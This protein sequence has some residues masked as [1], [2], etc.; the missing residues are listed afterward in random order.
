MTQKRNKA[1]RRRAALLA[2]SC[3][4]SFAVTGAAFGQA[5]PEIEATPGGTIRLSVKDA[6]LAQVLELLSIRTE[7]NIITSKNVSATISANLYDVTFEEALKAILEVNGFTSRTQGDF[8][9]IYTMEEAA[10]MD[11]RA[12]VSES[13]SFELEHLSAQDAIE[14]ITPMLSSEGVA[15]GNGDVAPGYEASPTNGGAD[16]YAFAAR[17]VVN[18]YEENLER[19]EMLLGEIDSAPQQVLVE[20]TIMQATVNEANAFGIDF[21]VIGSLNFTDLSNPLSGVSNLLAGNDDGPDNPATAD[22]GFEPLDNRGRGVTSTVGQTT[23]PGGLKAGIV[24]GDFAVFLRLLDEVTDTEVLARPKIMCLNRQ[25]ASVLVGNRVG[26]LST[27]ATETS[28]TQTVEYLDTGIQLKFRPFISPNGMIRLELQPSVSEAQLRN[29]TNQAGLAVTIPDELTNE[30][31][32][33][34]RI[35]DGETLVLGGLFRERNSKTRRQ[36][37]LLGDIPLLG[38]A[39][40][41]QDD[42]VNREEI[43]F[44]ITPTIMD[45]QMLWEI[46]DD[47]N[48]LAD[49]L[50]LGS[51]KGLLPFSRTRLTDNHNN[52]AIEAWRS[53][54]AKKALYHTN[55]SLRLAPNQPQMVSFRQSAMG[56]D[57]GSFQRSVLYRL[58][59]QELL[60]KTGPGAE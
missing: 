14:F 40:R 51:R 57:Q 33:N 6:D 9:Y 24:D 12:R 48:R 1:Q 8:I 35:R 46:G 2:W 56:S 47:A 3:A 11:A 15:S 59:H 41:G 44:L 22:N 58:F 17:I 29:V 4:A 31:T 23:G 10:E 60:E 42:T 55:A 28:S 39:F 38:A 27:T 54:E 34:V 16:S 32:T 37:P 26:Y 53:G 19:I 52:L 21:S 5:E 20:S 18:D 50:V 25:P 13:R 49:G 7:K 30:L 43:I 36:V 45:D